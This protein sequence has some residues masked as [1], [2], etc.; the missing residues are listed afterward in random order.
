MVPVVVLVLQ[1]PVLAA[2]VSVHFIVSVR[3]VLTQPESE[4]LV[5]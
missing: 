4:G 5:L 3:D 1:E 2:A